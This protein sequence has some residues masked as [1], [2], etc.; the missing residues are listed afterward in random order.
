MSKDDNLDKYYSSKYKY[1]IVI[2]ADFT[3]TQPTGQRIDLKLINQDGE[4]ILI[5]V[6][7]RLPE[8]INITAHDYTKEFL[9]NSYRQY[10]PNI[11][12]TKAEKIFIDNNKAFLI[13]Y[14]NPPKPLKALEIY[15]YK[16]SKTYVLTA[17]CNIE[18]FEEFE[19]IFLNTFHSMKFND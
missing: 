7:D 6:S 18:E 2:P 15:F 11:R 14:V 12:V 10:S 5:N 4:S 8:E 9:E 1:E 13:N 3:Q 17:T 16:A 19:K